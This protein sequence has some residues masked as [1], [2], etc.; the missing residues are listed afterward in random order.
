MKELE[1]LLFIM[2]SLRDPK[3]GCPWDSE[4]TIDSIK[5]YT[6]EEA[7]ELVDAIERD[8]ISGIKDELGD[9]LFH[10]IFYSEMADEQG[11]FNFEAIVKQLNEKLERRHPHVFSDAKMESS[12]Q[13][14]ALW[15]QIKQQERS[16]ANSEEEQK[17]KKLLDDVAKHMPAIQTASRLQKRAAS[18]GFDWTDSND[19][20]NKLEEELEELREAISKKDNIEHITEELGDLMFCCVNLARHCE[21]DSEL[22][23][24]NTNTKFIKRFNF[25]EETLAGMNKSLQEAT[26]EEMDNLW[27]EAKTK[28]T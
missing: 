11:H 2:K 5:G 22:A 28:L 26:L 24:R 17:E 13:V 18:V 27:D 7:Y 8:D 4:Q 9:L 6:I 25:I 21:I 15:E 14:K 12:D 1:K 23:L 20:F 16:D 3:E 10:I 19:I